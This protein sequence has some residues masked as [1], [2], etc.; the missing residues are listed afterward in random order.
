MNKILS[1]N[2]FLLPDSLIGTD[3]SI[4]LATASPR[5]IELFGLLGIPFQSQGADISE[6]I[7]DGESPDDSAQRL[8]DSK[9]MVLA[10]DYPDS[11]VI[12]ADTIVVIG[13]QI[14]GKPQ[15]PADAADMLERLSGRTHRV[16]TG[17]ALHRKNRRIQAGFVECTHVKFK[18]LT[19]SEI[20]D[21]IQTGEPLDKAGA[22][23]IQGKAGAFVE[24]IHGSYTNVVGL[25][26]ERLRKLLMDRLTEQSGESAS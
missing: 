8:A 25:P 20:N 14:L 1:T 4:I 23:G 17:V 15:D 9:A 13:N 18:T 7:Y 10:Q 16:L 2:D 11:W 22:Y 5:R 26:L 6:D 24:E 3:I 12:G 21:Y 19:P